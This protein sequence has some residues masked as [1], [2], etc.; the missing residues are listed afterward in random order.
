MFCSKK[1]V[2]CSIIF[3]SSL[4][5]SQNNVLMLKDSTWKQCVV[6][7]TVSILLKITRGRSGILASSP[8][9]SH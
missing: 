7:N 8:C 3:T 5:V 4:S 2:S 6:E 9:L 1:I